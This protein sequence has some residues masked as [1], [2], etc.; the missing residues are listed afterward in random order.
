MQ[1]Q[2]TYSIS[3]KNPSDQTATT[4]YNQTS[5]STPGVSIT[6]P[7]STVSVGS[8]TITLTK[9]AVTTAVATYAKVYNTLNSD[10]LYP[11]SGFS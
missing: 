9:T 4:R 11:V 2:T 7:S 5:G 10:V 6:T 8:Q 3:I 1:V